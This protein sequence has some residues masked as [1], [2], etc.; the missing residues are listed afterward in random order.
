[1]AGRMMDWD[2]VLFSTAKGCPIYRK[3]QSPSATRWGKM[4]KLAVMLPS[5]VDRGAG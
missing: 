4:N 5:H 3:T 2:D 1:M